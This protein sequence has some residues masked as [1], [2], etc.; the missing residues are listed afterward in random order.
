VRLV[1]ASQKFAWSRATNERWEVVVIA[2]LVHKVICIHKKLTAP[3][4]DGGGPGAQAL[5]E[6]PCAE[7]R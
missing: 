4:L 2:N 6:S 1:S 3:D 7:Q 5:W